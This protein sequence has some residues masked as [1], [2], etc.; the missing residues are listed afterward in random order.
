MKNELL[1]DSLPLIAAGLGDKLG[2]RVTVSG[3]QA[4]T[5]GDTINIPA[6]NITSKEEKDAVLGFMSH[7]AAHI[8][9][10]SWDGIDYSDLLV[11]V[12]KHFWNIF[13]DLRIEQAMIDSMVGTKKWIDQI[14]LNRQK[15]GKRKPIT[16]DAEPISIICD[17]LLFHCR[18]KYRKQAHLQP[19][20]DA[21]EDAFIGKVSWKLHTKL[22]ALL[23]SK[24]PS[25][26]SSVDAMNLAKEVETLLQQHEEEEPEQEE[27][28]PPEPESSEPDNSEEEADSSEDDA[29]SS[30]GEADSDG[31]EEDSEADS[32]NE[33]STEAGEEESNGNVSGN[34]EADAEE[35]DESS[36]DNQAQPNQSVS[37]QPSPSKEDVEAAIQA[38]LNASEEDIED[39]MDAFIAS[40]ETLAKANSSK[41]KEVSVPQACDA[42]AP[43]KGAGQYRLYRCKQTS[44]QLSAT[45]QGVV[46]QHLMVRSRTAT[47]GNRLNSKVLYRGATGDPRLF[48]TKQKKKEVDSIVEIALDNS[49]SM[50][51]QTTSDGKTLL[52]VA[53]D[54]QM[55]LALALEKIQGVNITASAFPTEGQRFE[56]FE[57]LKENESPSRV[58][59]DRLETLR[60][61]GYH[62][63]SA[64]AMWHCVKTVMQSRKKRKVILFITDGFP[65]ED[66]EQPLTDLVKKAEKNG[67][68]VIGIAIGEIANYQHQ[69][70]KHFNN[71]LFINDM[72]ELKKQMFDIARQVIVD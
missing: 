49:G 31:E 4:S 27:E 59:A 11:P 41:S 42:E 56:V 52:T 39:E 17:L 33:S 16:E 28:T 5:T 7:E 2:V 12:R 8:K 10:D 50:V 72:S 70:K 35:C 57:L 47:S 53:K 25:L 26:N 30:N 60:G 1:K 38:M 63:P 69:F 62:T 22:I 37:G 54:A 44:N 15:E 13:E 68:I 58:L 20:Y 46:Q 6:F 43:F 29:E 24:L 51:N 40:M 14:W 67:V 18:V 21:A 66:E 55:A 71:A 65:N 36:E 23:D 61:N 19:Y 64:T 3:N 45:L 48:K 34:E 9:F 32:G